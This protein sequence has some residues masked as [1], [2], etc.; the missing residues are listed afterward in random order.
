MKP[1]N[2]TF[3][4]NTEE[5]ELYA[6]ICKSTNKS[7]FIKDILLK[8]KKKEERKPKNIRGFLKLE[9]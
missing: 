6:W 4:N 9:E 3:K 2:L 7:C 8:A 1:I 5:Q